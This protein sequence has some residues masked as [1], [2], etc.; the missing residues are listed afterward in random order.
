MIAYVVVDIDRK[1]PFNFS[2]FHDTFES[3][4]AEATRLC[5]LEKRMFLVLKAVAKIEISIP[6]KISK[7][8]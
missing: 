6:T 8:E 2:V 5:S 1:Q 7:F 4:E 3:A